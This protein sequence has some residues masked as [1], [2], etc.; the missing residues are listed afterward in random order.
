MRSLLKNSCLLLLC[1]WFATA[2]ITPTVYHSYLS[3][4]E[5]GWR[6]SDTLV[7]QVPITDSLS[8][9][10]HLTAEVRNTNEYAYKNL[11]VVIA[12]NVADSA[13]FH[14]DTLEFILANKD[15]KWNGTGLGNLFQSALPIGTAVT[16][17]TGTYTFK[18]SHGMKDEQLKGI[19]DVGIRVEN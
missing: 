11:Y 8:A 12:Q 13:V 17:K 9:I 4:P 16:K 10:L 5:K 1:S 15:G 7:F 19:R 14:T 6:K 18:I 3:I 2:C